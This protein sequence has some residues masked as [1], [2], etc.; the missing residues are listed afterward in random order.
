[1][2]L[3]MP[4]YYKKFRCI[5]DKCRDNCCTAGWQI[6][7]DAPTKCRYDNMSDEYGVFIRKNISSDSCI[8][9]DENKRCP[10]LNE[11]NLCGIIVRYDENYTGEICREHPRFYQWFK[12]VKEGGIGLCCEAAAELILNSDKFSF[13]ETEIP[14]ED[15]GDYDEEL[16]DSLYEARKKIIAFL[17]DENLSLDKKIQSILDYSKKLQELIDNYNY[18]VPDIEINTDYEKNDLRKILEYF[19]SLDILRIEW[20]METEENIKLY[21]LAA[22][23]EKQFFEQNPAAEKYLKNIA[24]YFVWRYFMNAVYTEE[25]LSYIKIMAVSIAFLR[26]SFVCEW[27]KSGELSE[28]RCIEIVKEYSKEVEYS[29]ENINKMADDMYEKEIFAL[30]RIKGLFCCRL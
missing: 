8:I 23:K 28:K 22:D 13:Y 17:D 2:I 30:S 7:I 12:S 3:R 20:K 26:F 1:M 11:N 16:Y 9:L 27:I 4:E 25:F 14:D 10:F 15:C 29:E 24:V 18:T 21:D 19:L 5:A 6:E